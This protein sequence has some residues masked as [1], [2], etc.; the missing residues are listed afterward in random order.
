[1]EREEKQLI[2][3]VV[4]GSKAYGLDLPTSDTDIRGIY[5]TP[6][7]FR[8]GFGYKNQVADKKNDIVYYELNRFV[9]LLMDNNPNIIENLFSDIV[10]LKDD[11]INPLLKNRH[12]FLSKKIK[13]T[14][15]GY[16]ISQIKKARGL[17]KKVV[18]PVDK[19]RKTPLDF[20]YIFEKED[21]YMMLAKQW[22]HKHGKT[23]GFCGL[24]EMPNGPQL[25]KVHYDY[26][27]EEKN[28]NPRY[29]DI[30]PHGFRGIVNM[31]SDFIRHSEVPKGFYVESYLWYNMDGYTSHCKDHKEYWEW[32]AN[33]NPHRYNDNAKHGKGYDGKNLMHCVRM[34]EMAI[35]V[36]NTGDVVL[37]RPN[38][39]FLLGIR[40]GEHDYDDI[41]SLIGDRELELKEAADNSSL[42]DKVDFD[43]AHKIIL[44]IRQ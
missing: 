31:G 12:A 26:L 43:M 21:G 40:R 20:C 10:L 29:A 38:R 16:A 33:R 34:L 1:M 41:I 15:G 2:F 4:S 11:K 30:T 14:F 39:D 18:N 44:D 13:Y 17:N 35:E 24:T 23:Q 42:P 36:L 9:S 22:L 19:E 27:A 3:K 8:L 5:L 7:E 25:Y 32:V 37:R 6:N 28:D